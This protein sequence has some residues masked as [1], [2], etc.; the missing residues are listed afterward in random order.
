[1]AEVHEKVGVPTV[2]GIKESLVDYA[3]GIGG[4]LLY[5]ISQAVLGSGL[6]G[7]I[8]GACLAGAT[9]K[10]VRGEVI[11][12]ML[13]FQTGLTLIAANASASSSGQRS[14]I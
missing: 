14:V 6:F 10:G 2:N 3:L 1:M 13:G 8:A 5:G 12:T 4:G 11:A 9:I 7:G